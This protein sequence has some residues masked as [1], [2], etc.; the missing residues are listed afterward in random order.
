MTTVSEIKLLGT[1]ISNNLSWNSNTK[2]IIRKANKRMRILHHLSEYSVPVEDMTL[3]Y[4]LYIRSILEQSA[5]V[6]HSGLTQ[7]NRTD[8][9][10][11]QK[12]CL[13]VI[14]GESY[15]SYE[16]ALKKTNLISLDDRRKTLCLN[17]ARKCLVNQNTKDMFPKQTK[18]T[19]AITRFSEKY[20][21]TQKA[22][23]L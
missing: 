7:E 19:N 2:F 1:I 12:S 3:I 9:E 8:I 21:V 20:R 10:R 14:L 11:V 22:E 17:F 15:V 13:K 4:I 5:V 23:D 6:W 16:S 18:F